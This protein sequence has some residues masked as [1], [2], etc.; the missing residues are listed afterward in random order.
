MNWR[1][2]RSNALANDSSDFTALAGATYQLGLVIRYGDVRQFDAEP[3]KP[4]LEQL[5]LEGALALVGAANCDLAAAKKMLIGI[6]ELNKVALDYTSLDRRTALDQRT[7]KT[8]A[9]RSS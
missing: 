2:R 1:V 6:N 8:R 3:L 4:L 5:F 9:R 7:A